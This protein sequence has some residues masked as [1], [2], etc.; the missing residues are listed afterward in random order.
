MLESNHTVVRDDLDAVFPDVALHQSRD[1]WIQ[2]TQDMIRFLDEGYIEP[3]VDQ[4]F[5]RLQAYEPATHHHRP[6]HG[7]DHL[8]AG[9][10]IHS[11]EEGRAALDPLPDRP[12]VRHRSH[13]EDSRQINARQG[14]M[15]R[16]RAG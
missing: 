15:D 7:L 13:V 8:D 5:R 2:R 3:E 6:P 11:R 14:R 4:V 1:L 12:R 10:A 9:V 16:S